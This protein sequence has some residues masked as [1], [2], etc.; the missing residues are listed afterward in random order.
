MP[1]E[2]LDE[3]ELSEDDVGPAQPQHPSE[4]VPVK[5]H[6]QDSR[7]SPEDLEFQAKDVKMDDFLNDP[8]LSTKIFLSFHFREKGLYW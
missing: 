7:Y 4:D 5:P 1:S 3:E 6:G 8:E 2:E